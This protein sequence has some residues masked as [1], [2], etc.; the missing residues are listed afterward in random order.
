MLLCTAFLQAGDT[1][2]C[3]EHDFSMYAFYA[4]LGGANVQKRPKRA[5]FS[6]DVDAAVEALQTLR[7]AMLIFSNPCNPTSLVISK[8]NVRRLITAN[9]ETL[10]VLDEAYMEF[11]DE[12]LLD[13]I[14][15]FANLIILRTCSKA[16]GLAGLRLGFAVANKPIRDAL[17]AIKSPYNVNA[18]AQAIGTALLSQVDALRQGTAEI[19][20]QTRELSLGLRLMEQRF[21]AIQIIGDSANFVFLALNDPFSAPDAFAFLKGEGIVVRCFGERLRVTAGSKCE[22][23][24]FLCAFETYC[25]HTMNFIQSTDTSSV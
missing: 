20:A 16:V 15:N 1:F 19:V 3:F 9:P 12:S 5:D 6:I 11:A 17:H 13:E 10:V 21:P 2:L 22:N 4:H 7:P 25:L 14:G 24:A 18:L 23:K 8:A